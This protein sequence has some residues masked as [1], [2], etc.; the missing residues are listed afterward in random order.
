MFLGGLF[1]GERLFRRALIAMPRIEDP[2]YVKHRDDEGNRRIRKDL[3]GYSCHI[4][5][6]G[7]APLSRTEKEHQARIPRHKP[8][9][10]SQALRDAPGLHLVMNSVGNNADLAVDGGEVHFAAELSVQRGRSVTFQPSG[11]QAGNYYFGACGF[12][13]LRRDWQLLMPW[14]GAIKMS[15]LNFSRGTDFR[16]LWT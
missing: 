14:P 12:R 7:H 1:C 4:S 3:L 10:T 2:P 8:T 13:S 9:R 6:I 15:H 11:E 5:A 16:R